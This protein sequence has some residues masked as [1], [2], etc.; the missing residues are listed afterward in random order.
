MVLAQRVLIE[1][2]WVDFSLDF[3]VLIDNSF[4]LSLINFLFV[5]DLLVVQ[6]N[7]EQN[8]SVVFLQNI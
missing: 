2:H 4:S 8:L 6:I 7:V 1:Q 3:I 5:N